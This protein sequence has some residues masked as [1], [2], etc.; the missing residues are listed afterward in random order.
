MRNFL[1]TGLL[2]CLVPVWLVGVILGVVAAFLVVGF[3]F[4][5]AQVTRWVANAMEGPKP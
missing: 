2:L 1:A 5:S 3:R 4:G